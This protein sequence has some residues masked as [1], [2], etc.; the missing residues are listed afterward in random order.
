MSEPLLIAFIA[1]A[2]A[3]LSA[4]FAFSGSIIGYFINLRISKTTRK[5]NYVLTSLNEKLAAHQ[6]AFVLSFEL[7]SI[8]HKSDTDEGSKYINE[9]FS[10]WKQNCLYLEP[11][12]RKAFYN[13]VQTT[14]NYKIFLEGFRDG[15]TS[16][17]ELYGYWREIVNLPKIIETGINEPLI[18][19]IDYKTEINAE[20]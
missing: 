15:S 16:K 20:G 8:A 10:W 6:K 18:S 13:T 9:C 19:P 12:A 17:D 5:D 3:L 4:I 1:L 2:G 11:L 14:S 7:P